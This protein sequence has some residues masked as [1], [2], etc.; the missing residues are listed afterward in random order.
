M[1]FQVGT[2]CD[3]SFTDVTA[4]VICREMGYV[5]FTSWSYGNNWPALQDAYL[6]VLDNVACTDENAGIESCSFTVEHNCGHTEDVSLNC[7]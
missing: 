2:V 5:G 7:Y 3:D 4:A 1:T 6:T